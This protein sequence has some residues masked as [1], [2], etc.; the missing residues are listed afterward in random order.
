MFESGQEINARRRPA[1]K[2]RELIAELR[3]TASPKVIWRGLALIL[4]PSLLLLGLQIYQVAANVPELRRSQNLV[5]HTFEVVETAQGLERAVRDAERNQ[6][7]FLITGDASSLDPYTMSV[8]EVRTLLAKLKQLT[9][10]NPEQQRRWPLLED[11]INIKLVELK[12]AIDARRAGGIDAARQI[13]QSRVGADTMHAIVQIIGAAIAAEDNLL[14]EQQAMGNAAERRSAIVATLGSVAALIVIIIGS[15]LIIVGFRSVLRSERARRESEEKFR[16][17]LESAPDAMVI[18]DHKGTIVLVNEQTERFFGYPRAELVG[19]PVELLIP[20]RSRAQHIR[21]RAGFVA[22][23]HSRAMG[24]GFELYGR[25]KDGSEFPVEISLSPHRSPEGLWVSSA[26]RD[27]TRRMEAGKALARETQERERAEEI[28]RQVQKLE[29]L[30]QLTG[31]IAHDFNNML[32]VIIGSLEILQRRLKS[33]DPRIRDPVQSALQAVDRSAELTQRLLAFSRRQPLEPKP[34][35][36]NKL[37]AGMSN[38]LHRT[39]GEN[40]AIETVLAAGLWTTSA[41]VPQLENAVLNLAVNARDAMQNGGKLTIETANAYLD[42]AYAAAHTEVAPGQYVMLA[43]S[44]T[45]VGMSEKTLARAFEPFFTTKEAGRGTGLGLSQVYGFVKQSAGHIKI[46]SEPAEGTTVRLYLPRLADE[47]FDNLDLADIQPAPE[48]AASGTVLV[49]DDNELLLAAIAEMLEGQGYRALKATD[50]TTAL[51]LLETAP[52]IRLLFTD[53]GLPRGMDGRQLADEAQKLRPGL[54]VLFTTGY[55]QN[56]ITHQGRLD[57][58]VDFIAKPFTQ[59]AL[60]AR[61][62][63]VLAKAG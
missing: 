27:I 59:P 44:D 53:I 48:P 60:A 43:V 33:D 35:D 31:G 4:I 46:Y 51:R 14:K 62:R 36:V 10:D 55:A 6:R 30:G 49:V 15:G 28:V 1:E 54:P 57:P 21:Y 25:R 18:V 7:G 22:D 39:L 45:G 11:Q 16:G 24:S 9:A 12:S 40:I 5:A 20:E 26:I 63:R 37:V 19:K 52:D 34:V 56:A 47:T 32:G 58:G 61:I 38:L 29:V 42:E 13:L 17:L 50:G 8:Q 23:P 3:G 41:D 2:F